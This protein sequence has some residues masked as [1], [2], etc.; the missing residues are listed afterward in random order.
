MTT[1]QGHGLFTGRPLTFDMNILATSTGYPV[2]QFHTT[3]LDLA[4]DF[5]EL[6]ARQ[7]L[8]HLDT[9]RNLADDEA[10]AQAVRRPSAVQAAHPKIL[11][12]QRRA[13]QDLLRRHAPLE[14]AH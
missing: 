4:S 6:V 12:R 9:Q 10:D 5:F 8:L 3:P 13:I 2:D 11:H 1:N 7:R 14:Y